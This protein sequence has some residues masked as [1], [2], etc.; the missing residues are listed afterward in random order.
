VPR[1][2][3]SDHPRVGPPLAALAVFLA[4]C[5]VGGL[6]LGGVPLMEPDE[7]RYAAVGRAMWQTGDFVTPRVNGF[8]YLDKP[9]LLHWLTALSIGAFGPRE[10]AVRLSS[11]LAAAAG[12]TLVYAFGRRVGGHGAGLASAGVLAACVLWFAVGRV[13]RYDMLLTVSITASLWWAWLGTERGREGRRYYCQAAVAAALGVLVKGPVAL[14]LPGLILLPY[15][16]V[17]GRLRTLAQ[18]PWAL[19]LG[20]LVLIVVPWFALCEHANPGAARFFLM[21]EN[22]A[23]VKGEIDGTHHEPWWYLGPVLLGACLPWTLLLPGAAAG[24]TRGDEAQR[25]AGVLWLLWA[26]VPLLAFSL[27]KVKVPTYIL[28]SLPPLALLIGRYVSAP[29]SGG[30]GEALATGVLLAVLGAGLALLGPR[31]KYDL[32]YPLLGT[33]LGLGG[34]IAIVA[35]AVRAPKWALVAVGI[36]TL[37]FLHL[38]IA[39]GGPTSLFP[40]DR[41]LALEARELRRPGERIYCARKLSRGAVFYLDERL[42]VLGNMPAEYDFP[43]NQERLEGWVYPLEEAQDVL[44]RPPSALI[45]CRER[46]AEELRA[47]LGESIT[48]VAH[49]QRGLIFRTAPRRPAGEGPP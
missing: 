9:P 6:Q 29:R 5:A 24:A 46:Y 30:R 23:R 20:L 12:A 35:S 28:P 18:V 8:V 31:L 11:L 10:F 2:R 32:P 38:A 1:D 4:A 14:A 26:V 39:T 17:T 3:K 21:H 44:S 42:A 48:E 47:A 15:L 37:G 43:R 16:A 34:L 36:G 27:S 22:L 45:L 13:I 41:A 49:T 7:A 19:V 33:V 25:R 40:S